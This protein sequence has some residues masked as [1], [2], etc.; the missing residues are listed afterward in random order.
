ME[1]K[2]LNHSQSAIMYLVHH[3]FLPPELPQEDDFDLRY[4]A[5]LLDICFEALERFRLYV[6][7]EQ[8][9]VVQTV[10]DMV[11]NLKS[12]RDSSDGSIREDQLKE[13]MRRLC[14]KADGIIPLYIRAQNATVLISRAEKSINFEM[15]E[16]SPLNQ[17]VITTKGRLRRS[18]P[19]PAF[20]LDID[21]FEKTQFQAMVAH[22]LAEMS[23]QSAADTL[24]KVKRPAKCTLRIATQPIRM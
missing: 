7:P 4:E 18:F 15:F 12:V 21:T 6:G 1:G 3:I 14:N 16:L 8:R 11:S 17:A 9:V 10:I 20:A 13:A 24:P 2:L 22:T 5:I 23:H 19:G